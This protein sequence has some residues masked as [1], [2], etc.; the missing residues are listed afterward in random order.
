MTNVKFI[1]YTFRLAKEKI[2]YAGSIAYLCCY[3]LLWEM[4]GYAKWI[5]Q[6]LAN[7]SLGIKPEI[8][9]IKSIKI[10]HMKNYKWFSSQKNK[11]NK[12]QNFRSPL[13][14][15]F[16]SVKAE[17]GMFNKLSTWWN[18]NILGKNLAL[19]IKISPIHSIFD[20]P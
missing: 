6:L 13:W 8:Q 1:V 11:Q 16:L 12:K 15:I 2:K 19:I 10:I 5:F 20:I 3:W 9:E 4:L 7:A 18:Q 17:V 14:E